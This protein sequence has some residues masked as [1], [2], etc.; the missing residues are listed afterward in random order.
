MLAARSRAEDGNR[1]Q[2]QPATESV[3]VL[4]VG[5]GTAGAIAAIQAARAGA[6]TMLIEMVGQLGGTTT[7]G[8]VAYPGLFHAWCRQVIAGI[9]WELVH[10]SVQLDTGI[11]PDFSKPPRVHHLHQIH[12]NGPLYAAL[13]EEAFLEAGGRLHYY[14]LARTVRPV[15]TGYELELTGRESGRRVV[16]K[17]LVDCTGDANLI[18]KLGLPRRREKNTQP[19][20]MMFELGDCD[21]TK[22][23]ADLIEQRYREALRDKKL[24]PGDVANPKTRFVDFLRGRGPNAQHVLGADGSTSAGKTRA[25]IAGRQS[26]LRL[27]RFARSLPG[28]EKIRLL[29]MQT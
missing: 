13:L 19:G 12:V 26:V 14:E 3:D 17:Q 16:C 27:L 11:L 18:G 28:C 5:G 22:L 6:R 15:E 24:L 1:T 8:G 25:N 29:R 2:E 10:K 7:T 4:V 23:D 21:V 9:G 20:T